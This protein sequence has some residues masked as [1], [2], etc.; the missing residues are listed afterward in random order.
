VNAVKRGDLHA[1]IYDGTVLDYLVGQDDE[2]RLLTVGSW[3]A[4]TGYGVAFPRNSKHFNSFNKKIMDY[5]ENGDLERLRRFWLTGTCNPKKEEK[6]SSEPLAPEQ[7][8]SAF[9]ILMCG[10]ALAAGLCCL[11]HVYFNYLRPSIHKQ[12]TAGCCALIS[13]SV[14]KSLTFRGTVNEARQLM[15]SHKCSDPLC[16][17]QLWNVQHELESAKKRLFKLKAELRNRG[18]D[19][20]LPQ[21]NSY[22]II[23]RDDRDILDVP[24]SASD[25]EESED[26]NDDRNSLLEIVSNGETEYNYE[27]E[28][29][30]MGSR[31]SRI[32]STEMTELE[33]VL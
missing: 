5:S 31:I 13:L 21:T 6:R 29:S 7:F 3:Y 8:L 18:I 24:C 16:S 4:M 11:E 23:N 26:H 32:G 27:L 15:K 2:C 10:A 19:S 1:F 25:K 12:D 22:V 9:F 33:T 30:L 20:T 17:T 28:R 14:G